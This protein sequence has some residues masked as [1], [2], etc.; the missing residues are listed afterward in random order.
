MCTYR[1]RLPVGFLSRREVALSHRKDRLGKPADHGAPRNL[2][3]T[4][5]GSRAGGCADVAGQASGPCPGAASS[6]GSKQPGT[7]FAL[8]QWRGTGTTCSAASPCAAHGTRRGRL[9]VHDPDT[10]GGFREIC[11]RT[12][13]RPA[14]AP[15]AAACDE[16]GVPGVLCVEGRGPP[17]VGRARP[18]TP[19]KQLMASRPAEAARRPPVLTL[20]LSILRQDS[21][22][23]TVRRGRLA[24]GFL[25]GKD[26]GFVPPEALTG[27]TPAGKRGRSLTAPPRWA[28]C[29]FGRAVVWGSPAQSPWEGPLLPCSRGSGPVWDFSSFLN[30]PLGRHPQVLRCVFVLSVP[31]GAWLR[32]DGARW[33]CASAR[34]G[35][36]CR[37]SSFSG[38]FV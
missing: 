11:F 23:L 16:G 21:S 29:G 25:G 32:A 12:P 9:P 1:N 20:R 35:Q 3:D 13:S 4:V 26:C 33:F 38:T 10:K 14:W 7:L 22:P 30:P 37:L 15:H 34:C 27:R 31:A 6:A 19:A 28:L 36:R 2:P 24:S 17:G 18:A 5:L 8:A